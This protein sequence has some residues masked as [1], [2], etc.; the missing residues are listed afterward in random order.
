MEIDMTTS[1]GFLR[2]RTGP[3]EPRLHK[4]TLAGGLLAV[5][6]GALHITASALMRGDVWSQIADE[7]FLNT[8]SLHPSEERLAVAEAFWLTP[9]SFGVPFLLLGALVT[10]MARRGQRVPGLLGGGVVAWSVVL[11]LLG[12][13]DVGTM[14][15]MFV[16]LLL[17][18]G[19]RD[20]RR[21]SRAARPVV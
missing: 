6:G 4:L 12:G 3:A 21:I 10:W 17:A 14:L 18:A 8:V 20:G 16:G 9:G 19:D 2:G 15:I 13:F 11:G 1:H 7:G 5:S